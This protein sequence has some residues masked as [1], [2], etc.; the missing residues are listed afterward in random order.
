MWYDR[1][2][3][4]LKSRLYSLALFLLLV[5]ATPEIPVEWKGEHFDKAQ[6][7]A[8][9]RTKFV[10]FKASAQ[11][12]FITTPVRITLSNPLNGKLY[13]LTQET[14]KLGAGLRQIWKLP[15][16]KYDVESVSMIDTFGVKRSWKKEKKSAKVLVIRRQCL[17]NLG[18]WTVSPVGA[19]GVA[20]QFAMTPNDYREE[21]PKSDS[22]V[23]AVVDGY[24]GMVQE[25]LG[26]KKVIA[27]ANN[28]FESKS[29]MRQTIKFTRQIAMFYRLDLFKHNHRGRDVAKVL[30]TNDGLIRGCYTAALDVSDAIRGE[31]RFTFLLLSLI[32][33]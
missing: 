23:A 15:S 26:G 12:R 8:Y 4:H 1:D 2:M 30:D 7:G 22:V 17:S 27:A 21:G 33:I 28:N 18:T 3:I 29:D 11:T 9:L 24:S 20:V 5:A 14:S 25:M 32:H 6:G 31:L 10:G 16:G 19:D 13:V